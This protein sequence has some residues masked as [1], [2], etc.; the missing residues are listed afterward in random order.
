MYTC[1]F[2]FHDGGS[3]KSQDTKGLP[4]H[5]NVIQIRVML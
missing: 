2:L 1:Y 3:E 5:D 4:L